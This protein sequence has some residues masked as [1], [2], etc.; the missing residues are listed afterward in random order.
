MKEV[1]FLFFSFE[2]A[3]NDNVVVSD[4][5]FSISRLQSSS[6]CVQCVIRYEKIVCFFKLKPISM[7]DQQQCTSW[8][9]AFVL[10]LHVVQLELLFSNFFFAIL[11]VAE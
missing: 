2:L 7:D 6:K 5:H 10:R 9:L 11:T 4:V 8:F 1:N 3:Y